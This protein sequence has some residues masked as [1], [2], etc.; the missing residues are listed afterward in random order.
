[1]QERGENR[2]S[3]QIY[4][5]LRISTVFIASCSICSLQILLQRKLQ[6]PVNDHLLMILGIQKDYVLQ[7]KKVTNT[8]TTE[9]S[10][11]SHATK[12]LCI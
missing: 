8:I 7:L 1:M 9:E 6:E 12:D 5:V 4:S 2:R 10:V 11:S 3:Q